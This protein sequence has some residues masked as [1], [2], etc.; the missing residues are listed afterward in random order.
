MWVLLVLDRIL[1]GTRIPLAKVRPE[2]WVCTEP[3]LQPLFC[4]MDYLRGVRGCAL[5]S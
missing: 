1:T 5:G 3:R 4:K 2:G